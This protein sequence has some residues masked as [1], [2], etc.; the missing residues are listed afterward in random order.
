MIEKVVTNCL[1]GSTAMITLLS[2]KA[3]LSR[4]VW[5]VPLAFANVVGPAIA[6]ADDNRSAC[7]KRNSDELQVLIVVSAHTAR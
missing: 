3:D 7:D 5:S 1:R 2:E 4:S 6:M